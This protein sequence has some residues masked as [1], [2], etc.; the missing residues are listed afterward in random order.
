MRESQLGPDS[1][2]DKGIISLAHEICRANPMNHCFVSSYDTG[3]QA[4]VSN[5]FYRE[6]MKIGCPS[7]IDEWIALLDQSA[8]ILAQQVAP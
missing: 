8:N 6:K 1:N 2:V 3:I 4:E 5:L 7:F